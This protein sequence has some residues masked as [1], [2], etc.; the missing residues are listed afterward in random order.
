MRSRE[1]NRALVIDVRYSIGAASLLF[2][3]AFVM[4]ND[5]QNRFGS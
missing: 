1:L 4:A 5:D 3:T 2:L